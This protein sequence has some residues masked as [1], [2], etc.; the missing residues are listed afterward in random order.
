MAD[1]LKKLVVPQ[2]L[3]HIRPRRYKHDSIESSSRKSQQ[4]GGNKSQIYPLTV[5]ETADAYHAH[6]NSK[7]F[8]KCNAILD[9]SYN[10]KLLKTK[11]QH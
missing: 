2:K 5:K 3:A 8:F 4:G 7:H 1:V 9:K 11:M 6:A 10:F